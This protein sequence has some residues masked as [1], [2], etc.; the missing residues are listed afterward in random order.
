MVPVRLNAELVDRVDAI[1]PA[2][3]PREPYIRQLL[4]DYLDILEEQAG[5]A[6]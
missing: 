5:E 4:S 1:R 6:A 2:M 3:L